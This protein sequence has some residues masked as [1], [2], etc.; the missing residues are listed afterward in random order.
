MQVD[1]CEGFTIDELFGKT[2][3]GGSTYLVYH[4]L[5]SGGQVAN[6]S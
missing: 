1:K 5:L 4:K 6:A 2:E 3:E